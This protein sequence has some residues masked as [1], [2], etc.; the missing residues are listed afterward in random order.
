MKI[1][2][3]FDG[4]LVEHQYPKIGRCNFSSVE[5]VRKLQDAG[6]EVILNTM[7]CEFNNGS[8]G[9]AKRWLDNAWMVVKNRRELGREFKLDP[10]YPTP[11]KV[12]PVWDW[13]FFQREG[14]IFIDDQAHG[15]P[16]KKA[17]MTEGYMVDW[18]E[19]DKIFT[20]KGI[21]KI[22]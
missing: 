8:L 15:T 10:I 14:V 4:T 1:Y 19:L 16:L 21:Y 2:L 7:R 12:Q 22:N 5:I 6:H 3:D 20:E 11:Y 9:E 17:V 13:D 18:E